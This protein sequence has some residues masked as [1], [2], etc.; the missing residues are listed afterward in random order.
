MVS[1]SKNKCHVLDFIFRNSD[2][3]LAPFWSDIDFRGQSDRPIDK[4]GYVAYAVH[5]SFQT[6]AVS[7]N[8]FNKTT[9]FIRE[10]ANV[11]TFSPTM[12]IA[13]SWIRG[14]PYVYFQYDNQDEVSIFYF[15]MKIY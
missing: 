15:F 7:V 11:S 5:Q 4:K 1:F 9:T 8:L 10:N 2:N 13:V 6:D 12:I 3:F 14:K